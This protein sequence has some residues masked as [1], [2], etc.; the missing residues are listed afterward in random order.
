[1]QKRLKKMENSGSIKK[2]CENLSE[3]EKDS[4]ESLPINRRP[5]RAQNELSNQSIQNPTNP[6]PNPIPNRNAFQIPQIQALNN[7]F[8]DKFAPIPQIP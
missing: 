8:M 1:M 5:E 4:D 3:D 6:P 7:D 2:S